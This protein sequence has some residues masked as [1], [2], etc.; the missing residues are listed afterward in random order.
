M[1][2]IEDLDRQGGGSACNMAID[3]KRLDPDMT[4]ETMGAR[5]R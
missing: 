3:L 4:V 1:T 5:R 2:T